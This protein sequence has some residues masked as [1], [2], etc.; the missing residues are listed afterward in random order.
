[1]TMATIA[2]SNT[3]PADHGL[4]A[5]F[6]NLNLRFQAYRSEARERTRIMRELSTYSDDELCELGLSRCDIP[7]VAAGTYRR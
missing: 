2:R 6:H 3:S 5:R 4:A 7:A 1:M